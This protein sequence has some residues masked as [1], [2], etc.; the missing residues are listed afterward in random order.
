MKD[1]IRKALVLLTGVVGISTANA[2]VSFTEL[3]DQF[4]LSETEAVLS[5]QYR[6]STSLTI[7]LS[8]TA[9]N[10]VFTLMPSFYIPEG[11][12]LTVDGSGVSGLTTIRLKGGL[13]GTGTVAFGAGITKLVFGAA[14]TWSNILGDKNKMVALE[15][16]VSFAEA[17]G[18]LEITG[19]VSLVR[20]PTCSYTIAADTLVA[21]MG[22]NLFTG[23]TLT[24]DQGWDLMLNTGD[25]IAK[26][27]KIIVPTGRTLYHRPTRLY[28]VDASEGGHVQTWSGLRDVTHEVDIELD[29]GAFCTQSKTAG[30][31]LKGDLTGLGSVL[32]ANPGSLTFDGKIAF[33]GTLSL[34]SIVTD[35]CAFRAAAGSSLANVDITDVV[36]A[37]ITFAPQSAEELVVRSMTVS[38][39]GSAP[40][41]VKVGTGGTVRFGSV[42]GQYEFAG[43][44][45]GAKAILDS[46]SSVLNLHPGLTLAFASADAAVPLVVDAA[47]GNVWGFEN[48][49]SAQALLDLNYETLGE[50][51]E[52]VLGGKIELAK[53]I[54]VA[55]LRI[56]SGA[57]VKAVVG[58][59]TKVVNEGGTLELVKS[60][61]TKA[62]LWTD[63]SLASSVVKARAGAVGD[64]GWEPDDARINCFK[65]NQV[66]DWHDCRPAR[67]DYRIRATKCDPKGTDLTTDPSS[68]YYKIFPT[69]QEQDG[70]P[71]LYFT[72]T[73]TRARMRI[74]TG[75]GKDTTIN[76]KC[77]VLVF[78]GALG[79]G[80]AILCNTS[81]YLNRVKSLSSTYPTVDAPLV[82]ANTANLDFRK[83]GA[84]V[85]CEETG[86]DAGWQVLSFTC[87]DGIPI[88]A[89]GPASNP[90][91]GSYNGGQIYGE[92]LLFTEMPDAD[93]I[94]DMEKYLADKW[95]VEIA[96]EGPTSETV[97]PLTGSGTVKLAG[98]GVFDTTG[99]FSGTVDLNGNRM[100][101]GDIKVPFKAAQIP[102]KDRLIW[103]DARAEGAVVFGDDAEKPDEIK[104]IYARDNN[105][106]KTA[107]GDYYVTSPW[108]EGE[109]NT[110]NNRRVRYAGG[111]LDFRN[112]Y[113]YNDTRGNAL[114]M[115]KL[116]FVSQMPQYDSAA[117]EINVAAGFFALDSSRKGGGSLMLSVANGGDKLLRARG[118]SAGSAI[119]S[120]ESGS[121]VTIDTRLN[122]AAVE[123]TDPFSGGKDVMSFNVNDG[124]K[125]QVKT[126]G[127]CYPGTKSYNN[128]EMLGEWLLY[129]ENVPAAD[130]ERIEAYLTLKWKDELMAGFGETRD[131]SVSG[132][133]TIA[134]ANPESLP[135]LAQGFTGV[136]ELTKGAYA[137][138]LPKE[139]SEAVEAVKL[140]G[141]TVRMQGEVTI[142]L[143]ATAA[144]SGSYLLMS[145]AD[146]AAGTTFTLGTVADRKTREIVLSVRDNALYADVKPNGLVLIFR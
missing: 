67:Q 3:T 116:P 103:I 68:A 48:T 60:W 42:S 123:M 108:M 43:E 27:C 44:G 2:A 10:G 69:A 112:G 46:T 106:L 57:E 61:K 41:I 105:G 98:N 9:T 99:Y 134:V 53:P 140:P 59:G 141:Q 34:A 100:E 89:L 144:K 6:A 31:V 101:I 15:A 107:D 38:K 29:G 30:N 21:T 117:E 113:T 78:N 94:L 125:V 50:N 62:A 90:D 111:W 127:Y 81:G 56:A 139:G 75:I 52:I 110:N 128:N 33:S 146:F 119:W 133:G 49:S 145:A 129:S 74:A 77:A 45:S 19:G 82:Y 95:A 76:V 79:G 55:T 143:D 36:A 71:S 66:M 23:D 126:F 102:A 37:K 92:V 20:W 136:I 22:P 4:V 63:A 24:L 35:E 80:N 32:F 26:G 87:A 91:T 13:R 64:Y 115:R 132:A 121:T 11:V 109:E 5:T 51:A 83:N 135:T 39:V 96:H 124:V 73:G 12:T 28:A 85:D 18:S 72:R 17:N 86:L 93:E 97:Y 65:E 58:S 120:L 104:M 1:R 54:P 114:F 16:D 118:S 88:A 137:F 130:R 70:R 84:A 7:K 131:M 138:T 142:D 25:A 8:G 122:G 47:S 40:P 14:P